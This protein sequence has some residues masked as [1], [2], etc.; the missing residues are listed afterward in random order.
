MFQK[1]S[2]ERAATFRKWARDNYTPEPPNAVW[3]P[4]VRDEWEKIRAEQL[5]NKGV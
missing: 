5:V 1:L 3:H 2:P 4:V